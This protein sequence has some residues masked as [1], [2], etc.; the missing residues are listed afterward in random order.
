MRI[1]QVHI[2]QF[3]ELI[4]WPIDGFGEGMTVLFGR[5]EAGKTSLLEFIRRTLFGY[6]SRPKNKYEAIN[7]LPPAGSLSL[8]LNNNSTIKVSRKNVSKGEPEI[9]HDGKL[10]RGESALREFIG[11]IPESVFSRVYAIG[12]DDLHTVE[13]LREAELKGVLFGAGAGVIDPMRARALFTGEKEALFKSAR[14][15]THKI[16]LAA[17][18]LRDLDRKLKEARSQIDGFD[19]LVE[20]MRQVEASIESLR[21]QRR[22]CDRRL[23]RRQGLIKVYPDFVSLMQ[24]RQALKELGDI[25][26]VP[27]TVITEVERIQ[28]AKEIRTTALSDLDK[29]IITIKARIAVI[30]VDEAVIAARDR[31]EALKAQ[32]K[33]FN[34]ADNDLSGVKAERDEL[35][36][37]IG[38][39]I[40]SID[41]S[42]TIEK[43]AEFSLDAVDRQTVQEYSEKFQSL[44][45]RM[46]IVKSN[47][48]QARSESAKQTSI[49]SNAWIPLG[50]AILALIGAATGIYLSNW[51]LAG[52]AGVVLFVS[53][54]WWL[55]ARK[56][57]GRSEQESIFDG[58]TDI[59]GELER[60][61]DEWKPVARSFG[62]D[63]SLLPDAV[64]E[65]LGTIKSIQDNLKYLRDDES[66]IAKMEEQISS[67]MSEY[68]SLLNKLDGISHPANFVAGIAVLD[69][70][71]QKH[72]KNQADR[73]G[74]QR[75]LN[76]TE[77]NKALLL[78][79]EV[80]EAEALR[81]LLKGHGLESVDEYIRRLKLCE[82]K[83]A[84][85]KTVSECEN[86]IARE[87]GFGEK[88][89]EAIERLGEVNPESLA[90]EVNELEAEHA[91]LD[92]Q[93]G[94]ANGQCGEYREQIRQ[95]QSRDDISSMMLSRASRL[96][97]Y[98]RLVAK[99]ITTHTAEFV[100]DRAMAFYEQHRQ[101]AVIQCA[102]DY[103]R[104]LTCDK[105]DHL[106]QSLGTG[107]VEIVDT[108]GNRKAVGILSRGTREQL[109]LALRLAAIEEF[110]QHS[111]PMPF[112]IDDILVN[113]DDKR[114]AATSQTLVEFARRR[115]VIMLTC[116]ADTRDR[117]EK[118][119]ATCLILSA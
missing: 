86:S 92:E 52:F 111:E 13:I 84:L 105:Y 93:I 112:I 103:F 108:A 22:E 85:E 55:D 60:L 8:R 73:E 42:W 40:K 65:S 94:H 90:Q 96:E 110:E 100:L 7:G 76:E 106:V 32:V 104:R 1:E 26:N 117:F 14:A 82:Q 47:A 50:M 27:E 5:N 113:F 54:T 57:S 114:R 44:K 87:V 29:K 97:Q 58:A 56:Q 25:K 71:L 66:R 30:V 20:M 91:K 23:K 17:K 109:Y 77:N 78:E 2:E 68:E 39:D 15:H 31:I 83:D 45:H 9:E 11:K 72:S 98:H 43:A 81:E 119:G 48:E 95:L 99:Y 33:S 64:R 51:W 41:D 116:H 53:G 89:D 4:D 79:Q 21:E 70:H 102:G 115:Q 19:G 38:K 75:Q 28:K 61:R 37:R 35:R 118:L 34:D 10:L 24:A 6:P 49:S 3:G 101:P 16:N 36:E 80:D 12:L 69:E 74:F 107:E 59:Q 46:D 62:F 63:E 88:L 18:E 67:V